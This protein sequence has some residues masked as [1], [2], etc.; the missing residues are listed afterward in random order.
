MDESE[1]AAFEAQFGLDK[2]ANDWQL[3]GLSN[4]QISGGY[5]G[6]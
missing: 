3:G 2:A 1:L 4:Y 5:D 6:E